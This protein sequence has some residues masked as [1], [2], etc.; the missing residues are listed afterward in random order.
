M[1]ENPY[2]PPE[3]SA[4]VSGV[5]QDGVLGQYSKPLLVVAVLLA[6]T[7]GYVFASAISKPQGFEEWV[8]PTLFGAPA[9]A[10]LLTAINCAIYRNRWRATLSEF[11]SIIRIGVTIIG[12][13]AAGYIAFMA[14]CCCTN[15]VAV[16]PRSYSP[17]AIFGGVVTF[18]STLIGCLAVAGLFRLIRPK[19]VA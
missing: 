18:L 16:Q 15:A 1:S 6:T 12:F 8:V 7:A 4:A 14:T 9:I 2:S 17:P 3:S 5:L 11:G 10:I 13:G 19:D